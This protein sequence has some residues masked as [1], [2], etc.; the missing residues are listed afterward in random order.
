MRNKQDLNIADSSVIVHHPVQY[1]LWTLHL[2]SWTSS[3]PL[4]EHCDALCV[5][6]RG[7][8]GF[9]LLVSS[10]AVLFVAVLHLDVSVVMLWRFSSGLR[11]SYS[12]SCSF[13][14]SC[15]KSHRLGLP[16]FDAFHLRCSFRFCLA[17][18]TIAD[19]L[20]HLNSSSI[21]L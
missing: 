2:S 20:A 12:R 3:F 7:P 13:D 4:C 9:S 15:A 17:S 5:F 1:L 18:F 10:W 11:H 8:W 19:S 14:S 21:F 6:H 16:N